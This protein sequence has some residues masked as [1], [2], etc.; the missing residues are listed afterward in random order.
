MVP[1]IFEDF[2]PSSKKFVATS[3]EIL[4]NTWLLLIMINLQRDGKTNLMLLFENQK[5]FFKFK[6]LPL[7]GAF[8][9]NI[10]CFGY[11]I[12]IQFNNTPSK[13]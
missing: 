10:K 7:H 5:A 3:L 2:E 4:E 11:K 6:L 1:D 12:R 13:V 9:P 8:L